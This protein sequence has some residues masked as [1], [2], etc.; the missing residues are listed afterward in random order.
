[1]KNP[2][3]KKC[4]KSNDEETNIETVKSSINIIPMQKKRFL[5]K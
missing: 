2:E 3:N 5:E 4:N 1:M